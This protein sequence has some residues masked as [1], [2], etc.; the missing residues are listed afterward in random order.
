MANIMLTYRC[1]L[2]CPYCFANEFVNHASFDITMEN[3][4]AALAFVKSSGEGHVG[5]IG[6]EPTVHGRFGEILQLLAEDEQIRSVTIYTN[7]I[8]MDE[9]LAFMQNEKF[10]LLVNCNSPADIGERSFAALRENLDRV[11]QIPD[12]WKRV[13]L[14]IN[15]YKDEL[16]Y[17]HILELLRR[18]GLH[19]VRMSVTVP[20]MDAGKKADSLEYLT[21]R[22]DYILRFILDCAARDIAPYFDCNI[23]PRCVWTPEQA[24]AVEGVIGQFHLKKTNLRGDG[25]FCRPVIDILPDLHAVRCFGTSDFTK[26]SIGDFRCLDDLR[27][28]YVNLIDC[29]VTACMKKPACRDCYERKVLRCTAGCLAFLRD[30]LTERIAADGEG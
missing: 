6:G 21:S 2:R 20:N 29:R 28:Y 4:R 17:G 23:I 24:A 18:C 25:S 15:L 14:G 7:G 9:C 27:N 8:K 3:F 19:R 26:V 16:D 22:R 1:N 13:N 5:L 11:F 30:A 12:V 10:N